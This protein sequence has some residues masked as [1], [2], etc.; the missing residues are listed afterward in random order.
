MRIL[1]SD[2]RCVSLMGVTIHYPDRLSDPKQLPELII[3]IQQSCRALNWPSIDMNERL[4]P[5]WRRH[6]GISAGE[7]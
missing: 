2:G 5:D 3:A 6:W 4:L 7:N 1:A